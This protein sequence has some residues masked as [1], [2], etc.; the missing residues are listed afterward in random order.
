MSHVG[1]FV[2][3]VIVSLGRTIGL[4]GESLYERTVNG[5]GNHF[6]GSRSVQRSGRCATNVCV[7]AST[8]ASAGPGPNQSNRSSSGPI[9]WSNSQLGS[10]VAAFAADDAGNDRVAAFL[11]EP[12]ARVVG[13][14]PVL[15]GMAV[16]GLHSD[17]VATGGM[18][19]EHT[20]TE[21]VVLG[22]SAVLI[23]LDFL[24]GQNR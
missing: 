15:P 11:Q 7:S 9:T 1:P 21:V 3:V 2:I 6:G 24:S 16:V 12:E 10:A 19:P 5:A 23:S 17:G 22:F 13:L 14:G 18:M 8:S 4:V 20:G